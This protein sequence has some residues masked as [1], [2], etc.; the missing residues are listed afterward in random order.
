MYQLGWSVKVCV[1]NE[2]ILACKD[3]PVIYSEFQA[4]G[5]W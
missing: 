3:G 5:F 4:E 1:Y 2:K